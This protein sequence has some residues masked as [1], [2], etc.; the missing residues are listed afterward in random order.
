M[1]LTNSLSVELVMRQETRYKVCPC[2]SSNLLLTFKLVCYICDE[3]RG[4]IIARVNADSN[5]PISE[6]HRFSDTPNAVAALNLTLNTVHES[7]L[8]FTEAEK[9]LLRWHHCLGQHLS[10]CKI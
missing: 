10:F 8:N 7:S 2:E 5:L 3:T 6:A 4:E 9:E 1:K